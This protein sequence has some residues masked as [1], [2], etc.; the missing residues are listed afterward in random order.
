[1][2]AR[3][4]RPVHIAFG[5]TPAEQVAQKL[6]RA[7]KRNYIEQ[8]VNPIPVHP[9]L[10]LWALAPRLATSLFNLLQVNQFMKNVAMISEKDSSVL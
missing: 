1:M 10:A 8:V 4:K 3:Y 9:V 5:T 6:V 2:W 7:I